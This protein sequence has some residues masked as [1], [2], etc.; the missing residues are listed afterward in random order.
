MKNNRVLCA[1]VELPLS[2]YKKETQEKIRKMLEGRSS[3]GVIEGSDILQ[4][5]DLLGENLG[6]I[7]PHSG[8]GE[9]SVNVIFYRDEDNVIKHEV[10][11]P[12]GRYPIALLGKIIA[13]GKTVDKFASCEC[14]K[15]LKSPDD[16]VRI[17][18]ELWG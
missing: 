12:A 1:A 6:T 14:V 4:C 5:D 3:S 17:L 18:T 13:R 7:G 15:N 8:F 9:Y 16:M 10:I 2:D 11:Y